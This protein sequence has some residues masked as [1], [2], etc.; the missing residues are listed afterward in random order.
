MNREKV[1]FITGAGRGMGKIIAI[2][3]LNA[4][5]I[6]EQKIVDLQAQVNA[7]RELSSAMAY[8]D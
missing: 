3:A 4:G 6:A 8:E 5:G 2:A 1:W 7:Y